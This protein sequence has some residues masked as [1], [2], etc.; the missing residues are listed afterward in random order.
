MALEWKPEYSVN[1]KLIDDQHKELLKILNEL[2][3]TERNPGG[4]LPELAFTKI[5]GYTQYHF[6]TEERYFA[7][8]NYDGA[9]PH[10]AAHQKL[11]AQ[12]AEFRRKFNDEGILEIKDLVKFVEGWFIDHD[13]MMDKGFTKC[14]NDHGLY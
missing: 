4:L 13:T 9:V 6:A 3:G 7:L 5:F 11:L 10:I 1:V 12:A 8:F 14:F 2:E